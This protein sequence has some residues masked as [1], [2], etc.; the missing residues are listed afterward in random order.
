MGGSRRKYLKNRRDRNQALEDLRKEAEKEPCVYDEIK[1][2]R[3]KLRKNQE[4]E[5]RSLRRI[6]KIGWSLSLWSLKFTKK[7]STRIGRKNN[8]NREKVKKMMQI[9]PLFCAVLRK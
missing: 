1:C 9:Y 6:V 3:N 5:K 2:R 7:I 4:K 8:E